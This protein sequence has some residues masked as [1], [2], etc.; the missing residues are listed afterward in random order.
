MQ[1]RSVAVVGAG[2][3]GLSCARRLQQ[4]GHRVRVLD[5]GRAPGG[6]I[7]TRRLEQA[8]FDHGAQYFTVSDPG[9]GA[10]VD[11][12]AAAGQVARWTPRWPGGE[13]ETRDLWV[14]VPGAAALPK[15]LAQGLDLSLGCRVTRL[16]RQGPQWQL[17]DDAGREYPGFDFVVL[18]IPAP[19]ALALARAHSAAV[20]ALA[21]VRMSPCWAVLVAFDTPLGAAL[22]AGFS[23][24]PLLPWVARN[25]SK[26]RRSG[27]DA[28]VL[29]AAAGWSASRLEALPGE[30]EKALMERLPA[31]LGTTLPPAALVQA[32]RWRHA[33]VDA[34]LGEYYV[35]DGESALAFCGDWCL[36]ARVEAAFLSGD[37]LG[38]ALAE[39]LAT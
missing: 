34:P 35:L 15:W 36:D 4:A 11:E 8:S 32:H 30:V 28:W 33:R 19:Q 37:A 1:M 22:D 9:F 10:L 2:L 26:P 7:A 16:A 6:R 17:T 38:R 12:A 20:Q 21:A 24:D 39:R 13:Q 3:A 18:A 27:L 23:D 14:G 5:K 31:R 25:S 29:H